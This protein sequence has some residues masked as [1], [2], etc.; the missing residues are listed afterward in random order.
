MVLYF[1]RRQVNKDCPWRHGPQP[2]Q[3]N[4]NSRRDVGNYK[5]LRRLLLPAENDILFLGDDCYTGTVFAVRFPLVLVSLSRKKK[6]MRTEGPEGT[7]NADVLSG[8][9]LVE[10]RACRCDD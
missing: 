1:L 4:S 2:S 3:S 8:T 9:E 5:Q 6:Q 10:A 7:K